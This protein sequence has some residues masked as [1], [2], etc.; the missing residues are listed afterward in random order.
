MGIFGGW[1]LLIWGWQVEVSRTFR[2]A[3][4]PAGAGFFAE[5]FRLIGSSTNQ[6][7]VLKRFDADGDGK[8]NETELATMRE[9]AARRRGTNAP[10]AGSLVN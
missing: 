2:V 9:W 4:R 3:G 8:L 5:R 7:D 6:Q 1:L 10:P